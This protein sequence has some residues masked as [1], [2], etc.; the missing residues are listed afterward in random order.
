ML[1][2]DNPLYLEFQ[3]LFGQIKAEFSRLQASNTELIRENRE[4]KTQLSKANQEA[5]EKEAFN[6]LA[7]TDSERIQMKQKVVSLIEK[8]DQQ[9]KSGGDGEL[10]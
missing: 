6:G 1:L 5:S 7:M 10:N 2:S 8:I 9:L 4:L 3:N